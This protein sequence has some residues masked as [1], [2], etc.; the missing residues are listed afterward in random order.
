MDPGEPLTLNESWLIQ[1]GWP[2]DHDDREARDKFN[3]TFGFAVLNR[4]TVRLIAAC[5][6]ILEVGAG[7][8]YWAMELDQAGADIVA[9]DPGADGYFPNSPRWSRVERVDGLTALEKHPGRSLLMCWPEIDPWPGEVV[10]RFSGERVIYV[11]EN[12]NGHT[13]GGSMFDALED[14]YRLEEEL[15]IPRFSRIND[16]VRVWRRK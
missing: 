7:T 3:R 11:G 9:T 6:P 4:R 2:E 10:E 16:R 5:S 14:G 8:G 13:G 15:E 1:R 12:R